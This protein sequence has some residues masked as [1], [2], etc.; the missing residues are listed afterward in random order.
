MHIDLKNNRR[1]SEVVVLSSF[2]WEE[3]GVSGWRVALICYTRQSISDFMG[4]AENTYGEAIRE[5]LDVYD[6]RM[7][8]Y[9]KDGPSLATYLGRGKV[10][11]QIAYDGETKYQDFHCHV[12]PLVYVSNIASSITLATF[13]NRRMSTGSYT[14]GGPA[15]S[16]SLDGSEGTMS[17][18]SRRS[19]AWSRFGLKISL[20][21]YTMEQN[22]SRKSCKS[23]ASK[24]IPP[25]RRR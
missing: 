22:Q 16:I 5:L 14:T 13:K 3:E 8:P 7:E 18:R 1:H 25:R 24:R 15:R 17:L 9:R 10:L 4:R 11:T 2:F 6:T 19:S 21:K 23:M 12:D 20:L